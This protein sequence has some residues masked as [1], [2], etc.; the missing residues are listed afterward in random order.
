MIP[1]AIVNRRQKKKDSRRAMKM[2]EG[3]FSLQHFA[4]NSHGE[5]MKHPSFIY[6]YTKI[7]YSSRFA[8]DELLTP[9][10]LP[11]IQ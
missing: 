6:I 11:S 3:E 2:E 4:L 8:N 1:D 9:I 7:S 10:L 5:I